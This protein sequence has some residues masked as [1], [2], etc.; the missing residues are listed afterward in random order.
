MLNK[1]IRN[2]SITVSALIV[3][4]LTTVLC[5]SVMATS[6]NLLP[7]MPE[8]VIE[9]GYSDTFEV[10][11]CKASAKIVNSDL[12]SNLKVTLKNVSEGLVKSSV[13]F[14]VL[15]PTSAN[16]VNIKINGKKISFDRKNPRYSFQLES[17]AEIKFEISAKQS[18]NYSVDSVR[19]ALRE[20]EEGLAKAGK[21]KKRFAFDE[22]TRFFDNEKFGKR[23]MVGPLVSK[24]GIFPVS[25]KDVKIEISVPKDFVIFSQF[26]KNWEEASNNANKT[27]VFNM[28]EN[29]DATVFLPESDYKDFETRQKILSSKE[30]LH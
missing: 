29:F 27:Y 21:S 9:K 26:A 6:K 12:S 10:T 7:R 28:I 19:K 3:L 2:L 25:F 11:D 5:N 16:A 8:I 23:F 1:K 4:M 30:F 17:N 14:R 18:I 13:K 20:R 15:Y 24:W 22:F